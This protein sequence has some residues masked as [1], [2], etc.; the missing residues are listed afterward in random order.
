MFKCDFEHGLQ[1]EIGPLRWFDYRAWLVDIIATRLHV[2]YDA[3]PAMHSFCNSCQRALG[4]G[5]N[6]ARIIGQS[7]HPKKDVGLRVIQGTMTLGVSS[8]A[9][10]SRKSGAIR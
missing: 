5:I 10:S 2:C 9:S 3:D 4:P 6:P 1:A 7:H 8:N